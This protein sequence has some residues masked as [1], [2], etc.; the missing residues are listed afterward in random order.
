[1]YLHVCLCE[2]VCEGAYLF[3]HVSVFGHVCVL[4]W[5]T[6]L[7]VCEYILTYM[8]VC[9][10]VCV[11]ACLSMCVYNSNVFVCVSAAA[12]QEGAAKS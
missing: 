1:M 10:C 2:R 5:A 4:E 6:G 11:C 9:V 7:C 3:G 8:C 12:G